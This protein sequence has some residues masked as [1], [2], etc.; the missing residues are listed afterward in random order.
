MDNMYKCTNTSVVVK[1]RDSHPGYELTEQGR[2]GPY[3]DVRFQ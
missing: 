2:R 1:G 3:R